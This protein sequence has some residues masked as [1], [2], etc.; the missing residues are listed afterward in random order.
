MSIGTKLE[1]IGTDIV[2]GIEYP[3]KLINKTSAVLDVVITNEADL[4]NVFKGFLQEAIKIAGDA[5]QVEATKGFDF[6]TDAAAIAD[7]KALFT[8]LTSAVIP[9]IEK[10]YG[11]IDTAVKS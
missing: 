7:I 10:V 1:E 9:E 6:T 2:K 11:A 3:F 5:S 8:Y 4:K